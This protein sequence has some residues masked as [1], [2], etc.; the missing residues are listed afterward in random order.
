M[1][2]INS[3]KYRR[4]YMKVLHYL[5]KKIKIVNLLRRI[6][7]LLWSNKKKK[8][9]RKIKNKKIQLLMMYYWMYLMPLGKIKLI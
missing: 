4:R 3:N 9:K 7:D 8:N 2:L 6:E 5:H 1:V